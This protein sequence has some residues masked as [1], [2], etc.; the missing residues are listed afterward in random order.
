M[1][2]DMHFGG[3]RYLW[4]FGDSGDAEIAKAVGAQFPEIAGKRVKQVEA[5]FMYW[6]KANQIHIWFVKNV[7][8]GVDECQETPVSIEQLVQLQEVCESVLADHSRAAELLPAQSGFF[9]G[10]TDYDEWY[11]RDVEDTLK[12]LNSMITMGALN[13]NLKSWDFY[14]QSSW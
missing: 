9:F 6:R 1:G 4:D 11:F 2:L 8:A 7:Q 12:W 3:R 14:Y 10:G 13:E 5:E